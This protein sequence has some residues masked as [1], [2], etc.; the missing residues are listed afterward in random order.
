MRLSRRHFPILA[1]ATALLVVAAGPWA[2][3]FLIVASLLLMG[4]Y[5]GEERI[6]A[7]RRARAV[8]S[9]RAPRARWS[10]RNATALVSSLERAPRSERGPPALVAV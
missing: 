9:A 4:R 10:C 7:A 2:A 1:L 6:L 3:P 8:P 5:V